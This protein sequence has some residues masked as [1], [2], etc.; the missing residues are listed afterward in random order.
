MLDDAARRG[1]P[2]FQAYPRLGEAVPWLPLGDWPTPVTE[3]RHFAA[4]QK[5][6][7]LHVKREDLSHPECGGNKVRSLEFL[8]ADA[9]QRGA[10]TILTLGAVGSHHVSRTAWHAGQLGMDMI[11]LVVHQPGAP[12]VQQNLLRGLAVGARYAPTGY[13]L[14]GP[15]LV[16]HLL[17]SRGRRGDRPIVYAPSGGTSPLSCLGHVS[18]ALELKQQIEAGVLPE[19]DFIYVALGSLGTAAGLAVGCKLAGLRSRLVGVVVFHRWFCT[20]GRWVRLARRVHRLMR[21]LDPSVPEVDLPK[22]E[23]SVVRTALGRGY[24]HV[25]DAAERLIQEMP[26]AE[27]IELDGTYSAKTLDGALQHIRHHRLSDKTHLFWHT[28]QPVAPRLPVPQNTASLPR[29]LRRY[30]QGA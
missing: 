22:S 13:A 29:G 30:F 23:F 15:R 14:L 17:R 7:A 28:Y 25:T 21:R 26:A 5:L 4:A 2:L 16:W 19:P 12:Y 20:A 8:L 18:A 9:R 6:K 1:L 24:A 27:Q 10:G 3:A 11:G